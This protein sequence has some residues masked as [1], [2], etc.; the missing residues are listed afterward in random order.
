MLIA[1]KDVWD[2]Y[3]IATKANWRN[4]V[5]VQTVYPQAEA[6]SNLTI[7]NIMS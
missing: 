6:V 3:G 4:L 1:V 5:E 2:W 7:F